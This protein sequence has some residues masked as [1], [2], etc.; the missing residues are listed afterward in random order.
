MTNEQFKSAI[1]YELKEHGFD[2]QVV[3]VFDAPHIGNTTL[4]FKYDVTDAERD[5]LHKRWHCMINTNML[6]IKT[7]NEVATEISIHLSG[8]ANYSSKT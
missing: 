7:P 1:N 2:N 8:Y 5:Y 6:M 3:R 4:E